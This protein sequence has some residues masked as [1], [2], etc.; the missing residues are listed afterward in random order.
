L[1]LASR[2]AQAAPKGSSS[3]PGPSIY[4]QV[5]SA[6]AQKPAHSLRYVRATR[7]PQL[8]LIPAPKPQAL[9]PRRP[10]PPPSP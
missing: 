8:P 7:V 2:F 10:S 5:C 6:A 1:K 3:E 4:N 9:R